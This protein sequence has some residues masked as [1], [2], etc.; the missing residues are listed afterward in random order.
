MNQNVKQHTGRF[1]EVFMAFTHTKKVETESFIKSRIRIRIRSQTS[2]S[3]SDQK[4][5][6]PAGSGFASLTGSISDDLIMN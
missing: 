1:L 6:D 3:R 5:S 2:G 4:G